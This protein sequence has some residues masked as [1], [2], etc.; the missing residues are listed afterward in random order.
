MNIERIRNLIRAFYPYAKEKLGFDKPVRV[1]YIIDDL[2]NYNDPLGK[3]A[4]YAPD[5]KMITLFTLNRH[6]KDILRSF[7]HELTHHAQHCRGE[8]GDEKHNY[9]MVMLKTIHIC[10]KWKKKHI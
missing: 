6:P 9:K 1:K 7:A 8:F 3:T 4:Y 10:A 5:E 2:E